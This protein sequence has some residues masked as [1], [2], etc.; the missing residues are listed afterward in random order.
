LT[1]PYCGNSRWAR[2]QLAP[3]FASRELHNLEIPPADGFEVVRS[4]VKAHRAA[5][6]WTRAVAILP[7]YPVFLICFHRAAA[8]A[9][10]IFSHKRPI[11]SQ[12]RNIVDRPAV[13]N[14]VE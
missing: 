9:R 7:D 14:R 1:V 3:L 4:P 8:C 2:K 13:P 6:G 5:A 11:F 12:K 10:E